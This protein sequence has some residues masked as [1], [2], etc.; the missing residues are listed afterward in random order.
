M[1][2]GDGTEVNKTFL[3][4]EKPILTTMVQA[5]T[6]ERIKELIDLS[7]PEGAEAFGMQFEQ[8]KREFRSHK[9]YK[10]LFSH[11]DKP[12]YVTNYRYSQNEGKSDETLAE[13]LLELADCGATLCDVMGDIF[14][15]QPDEVA[16]SED[17]IEKQMNL[18]EN[19]H[20]KVPRF[21]CH[22]M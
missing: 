16:I 19:L 17:E 18:I 8:L 1:Q 4:Y 13:E 9:I 10:E 14:D 21:S 6:P 15:K 22:L 7:L 11:T 12:V 2:W 5:E 3:E 20:E